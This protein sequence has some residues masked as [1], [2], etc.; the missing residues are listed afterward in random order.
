VR[1][2][3]HLSVTPAEVRHAPLSRHEARRYEGGQAFAVSTGLGLPR[4]WAW[5]TGHALTG[6]GAALEGTRG[7]E[8]SGR[9]QEAVSGARAA[10]GRACD[11]LVERLLP[12]ATLVAVILSEGQLHV[13][14]VG[15]GRVYL[16]RGARPKRL[17]A[18]DEERA[19]LLHA[20]PSI[21]STPVEPGDRKSVV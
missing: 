9:L 7:Q 1:T 8:A 10:L 2:D 13:M 19:G 17:T 5:A 21:C 3:A 16:H 4:T 14:S 12:D 20:R 11:T 15:P 6:F 18:R